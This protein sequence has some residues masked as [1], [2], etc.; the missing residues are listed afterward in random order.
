M[1]HRTKKMLSILLTLAMVA[2][3]MPA[4]VFAAP[5]TFSDV[6]KS[7]WY[8]NDVQKAVDTG[9][10]NGYEDNT[11]RPM[12]NMSYAEAVKLAAVMYKLADT[13][14]N[15]FAPGNP[16]Y[17]P[18]V[19]YAKSKGIINGNYNWDQAAT[20]AGYM[21]I[22]AHAIPDHPANAA[23]KGLTAKNTVA[24]GSIP[25]VPMSHP[26][27]AEIYKLYRA[28]ILQ[29]NDAQHNC[30][31]D[32]N[33]RRSEVAAILTRMMNAG[34]RLSFS[35]GEETTPPK[36]PLTIIHHPKDTTVS[37]GSD[38]V[39]SVTVDDGKPP[40]T[41][42]W[43]FIYS[44]SDRIAHES[45][46]FSGTA[47]GTLT[48]KNCQLNENGSLYYCVISDATGNTKT[49]SRATLTVTTVPP[50]ITLQPANST[51]RA[52][53]DA[54]F[55]VNAT[56]GTPPYKYQWYNRDIGDYQDY[57]CRDSE[58]Y[59]NV[60]TAS[61]TVN[62]P[63][64]NQDGGTYYCVITDANGAKVT[65]AKAT[66]TVNPQPLTIVS[67]PQ[68][69]TV[70]RGELAVFRVVVTGG[71]G[72]YTYQWLLQAN[73]VLEG[74]YSGTQ[75]DELVVKKAQSYM[76]GLKYYCLITDYDGRKVLSGM[77]TLTVQ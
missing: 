70:K 11:Y 58:W 28:G 39:F 68:S 34:E 50:T 56:G 75:K 33:I 4:V 54:V 60:D 38:A 49:T 47:T 45:V 3:L 65:S 22:F 23:I 53:E 19:D 76:N 61:L 32:S 37:V 71:R 1:K 72:P 51:V 48:S 64:L 5:I 46:S 24:D 14:S 27:A 13:G 6:P 77:A 52:G 31:P 9:L 15:Y 36:M 26:Q 57:L 8:Y 55:R 16:W 25:D 10:I 62:R 7:E 74:D 30:R 42:T 17:Q 12:R 21:E 2:G 69:Q 73:P 35:M 59:S 43:H 29:G 20:R 63:M 66:L 40:Y 44:G 41:Y 67:Q 18:Y